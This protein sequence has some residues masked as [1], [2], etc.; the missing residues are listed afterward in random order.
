L[1]T[2]KLTATA[3]AA[4]IGGYTA[5]TAANVDEVAL[6]CSIDLAL[7]TFDTNTL[8]L[9]HTHTHTLADI[10]VEI[11]HYCCHA[12]SHTKFGK[13]RKF[14]GNLIDFIYLL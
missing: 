5:G 14:I 7:V 2:I 1:F 6:N 4:T 8:I 9:A 3:A 13:M 10:L 12:K 11:S